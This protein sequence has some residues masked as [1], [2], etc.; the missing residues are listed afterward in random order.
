MAARNLGRTLVI[1]GI[2]GIMAS[3]VW[4]EASYDAAMRALGRNM[5]I[6]HPLA[7]LLLTSVQC[8]Q[9]KANAILGTWPAYNPLALWLSFAVVLAG[10]VVIYR[11]APVGPAPITPAGEPRLLFAKLEPFYAWGRD[12][13][14]PIVRVVVG[15]ALWAGGIRK[16]MEGTFAGFAAN[17]MARRGIDPTIAYYVYFN[18]TIGAAMMMLG[19]FTRFVAALLAIELAVVTYVVLPNGFVVINPGGGWSYP[20][21]LGALCFAIAL[22][23]G[24][25][26]SLDRALGREL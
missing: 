5:K 10:L 3:I 8:T 1:I 6:S 16:L 23:G 20:F 4:W 11:T 17:S 9:A 14:W 12:L 2:I 26:Y 13:S 18:E 22:R 15:G 21:I 24:G 7:C 19:L 25:P